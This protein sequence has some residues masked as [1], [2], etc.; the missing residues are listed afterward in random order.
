[1]KSSRFEDFFH[2]FWAFFF[3]SCDADEIICMKN[4]KVGFSG[5]ASEVIEHYQGMYER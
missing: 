3:S 4:G 5:E 1:M 2:S